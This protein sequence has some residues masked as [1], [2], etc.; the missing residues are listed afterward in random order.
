MRIKN[1]KLYMED[2]SFE[3]GE[4]FIRDGLFAAPGEETEN[5]GEQE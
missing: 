3:E 5:S 2:K 4:I 1:V